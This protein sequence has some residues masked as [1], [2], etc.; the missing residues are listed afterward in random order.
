M[1][2][3][4]HA[5]HLDPKGR[6]ALPTRHR[7]F[8]EQEA[9]NSAIV[10]IDTEQFCLL[11]YPLPE[12]ERIEEKLNQLPGFDSAARRIQRLLLGHATELLIDGNGRI[13][14][15]P[16]LREYA[17]LDK[18]VVLVGQGKKFEIWSEHH[19]ELQ[20]TLWL[21]EQRQAKE[22]LPEAVRALIL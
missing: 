2:R 19:W 4:L 13:L 15:P 14:V 22:N 12:W 1:F 20:R 10:T 17:Q 8:W 21:N 9:K 18:K 3:G 6:L 11:L 5:I 16:I 7:A